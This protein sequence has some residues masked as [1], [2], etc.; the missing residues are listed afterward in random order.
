M[1]EEERARR[2]ALL[3]QREQMSE[4]YRLQCEKKQIDELKA[5]C[6]ALWLQL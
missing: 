6:E 4:L 3:R 1:N 5:E 2:L